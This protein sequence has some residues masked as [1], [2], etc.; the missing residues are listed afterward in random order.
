MAAVAAAAAVAVGRLLRLRVARVEGHW[1][2][3][4]GGGLLRGFLQPASADGDAAQ[5]RQVAHFTFQ[6]DPETVE[7]GEL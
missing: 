2:P 6:P 7:Y 5:K 3:L 1:H 4:S